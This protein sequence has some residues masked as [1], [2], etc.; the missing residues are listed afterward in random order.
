MG[1]EEAERKENG[2]KKFTKGMLAAAG[3]FFGVGVMLGCIGAIGDKYMDK[4]S[5]N[6]EE[7][8]SVKDVWDMLRKWDFRRI[9][10][11]GGGWALA[12]D[13]IEFDDGH[14]I[15]YGSFTDDGLRDTD[16]HNLDLEIGGGTLILR[17]GEEM[18]LKKEGGP[19]CQ[20]YMEG[21]TFY[22]KQKCP[23]G[24]GA[25]DLT[26]TLP[27]GIYLDEVDVEMGAGEVISMGLL[28]AENVKI[29]IDAG[30]ITMA[31]V[32]TETFEA[33]IAAGSVVV[34]QLDAKDCEIDVNMGNITLQESLVSGNMDAEV[35]MGDISIFLRDS[36][37]SHDYE[38]DC[39]MGEI[40]ISPEDGRTKEYSGFPHAMELSGSHSDGMSRYRL[41]CNMGSILLQFSGT[42]ANPGDADAA[43]TGVTDTAGEG[44]QK[45]EE[46]PE[47]EEAPEMEEMPEIE[48]VPEIKRI[49]GIED[50]WP[51]S[52]GREN[53]NTTAEN[54]SFEILISEPMALSI[55][56]ETESGE[57]DL[58]IENER[59]E[60]IF[61]KDDIR[62]GTYVVNA[63]SA[64]IYTVHFDCENHT[65]SFWIRPKG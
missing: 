16:V 41:A 50:N 14:D 28:T 5:G 62:T 54:F 37:E 60:E 46:E 24:G 1:R 48:E 36:Y 31:A 40:T 32:E 8:K 30:Q 4:K 59:G 22:L 34:Q 65:G 35:N 12:Y 11:G 7:F 25:S 39:D 15:V 55:S 56:C 33:E 13:G 20:Y 64:G 45:P 51:E 3:C 38:V 27:E 19:E 44:V 43:G 6:T 2:M 52:I 57:L 47:A 53:E 26:L 61:E 49:H 17:Y 29:D 9:K 63:G 10:G 42:Q 18:E 23:V 58:E 21:D